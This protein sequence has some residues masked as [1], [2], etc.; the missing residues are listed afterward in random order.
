MEGEKS[1]ETSESWEPLPPRTRKRKNNQENSTEIVVKSSKPSR[2][3]PSES[4]TASI[5]ANIKQRSDI[6]R[7][8]TT[9]ISKDG[10]A[11]KNFECIFC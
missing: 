8:A 11:G 1:K 3:Q 7:A 10:C 5:D 9:L 6:S 4:V 2:P